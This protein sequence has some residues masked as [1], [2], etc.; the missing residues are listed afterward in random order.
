MVW[1][2]CLGMYKDAEGKGTY[3]NSGETVLSEFP[4]EKLGQLAVEDSVSDELP[5][6]GQVGAKG[7][8]G[9]VGLFGGS[10]R[11]LGG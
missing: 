1:K 11:Y 2:Q 7:H 5:L 3:L 9:F 10:G 8:F 6:L 4:A